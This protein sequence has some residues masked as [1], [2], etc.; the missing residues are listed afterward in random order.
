MESVV[1]RGIDILIVCDLPGGGGLYYGAGQL[2]VKK[3]EATAYDTMAYSRGEIERIL[4]QG[5]NRGRQR[6]GILHSVD[7]SNVL[8]CSQ[9]WKRAA[10]EMASKHPF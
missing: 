8:A 5:F 10:S 3:S 4:Q 7:K 1:E 9:L 6:C 2:S